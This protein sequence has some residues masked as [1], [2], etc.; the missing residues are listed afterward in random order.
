MITD[1]LLLGQSNISK[2]WATTLLYFKEEPME[3][4]MRCSRCGKELE[5]GDCCFILCDAEEE[6]ATDYL[7]CESC[8]IDNPYLVDYLLG[9]VPKKDEEEK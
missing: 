2:R 4:K 5:E 6:K 3:C 1:L 9:H 8:G 7:L